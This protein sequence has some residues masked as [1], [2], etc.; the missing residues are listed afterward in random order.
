ML[1]TL[2]APPLTLLES[3]AKFDVDD[4]RW[5]P[6]RNLCCAAENFPPRRDFFFSDCGVPE[7]LGPWAL[8]WVTGRLG[9]L[10]CGGAATSIEG[11]D[12]RAL[13][14][15]L[16]RFFFCD[17]WPLLLTLVMVSVRSNPLWIELRRSSVFDFLKR[18][19]M[20]LKMSEGFLFS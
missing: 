19:P 12:R 15:K 6:G 1:C 5:V 11:R 7:R 18:P 14:R 13:G 8:S 16:D 10:I 3:F 20:L 2:S 17:V 9:S 4:P